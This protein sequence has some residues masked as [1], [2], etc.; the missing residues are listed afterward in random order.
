MYPLGSFWRE[1]A[2]VKVISAAMVRRSSLAGSQLSRGH[3]GPVT[4][5]LSERDG[6][7]EHAEADQEAVIA[8]ANVVSRAHMNDLTSSER[9]P[10]LVGGGRG[11]NDRYGYGCLEG[12][13]QPAAEVL[14]Q[15]KPV[16]AGEAAGIPGR[17][18]CTRSSLGTGQVNR[19]LHTA[20][21]RPGGMAADATCP[22]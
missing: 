16:V 12:L 13:Q 3:V 1:R 10:G 21:A 17:P 7:V 2:V 4:A 5:A 14:A 15:V 11:M 20:M 9:I 6:P 8:E 19:R 22:V 18:D